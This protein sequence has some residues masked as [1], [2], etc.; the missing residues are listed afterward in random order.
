M[1]KRIIPILLILFIIG[2]ALLSCKGGGKTD[3]SGSAGTPG[4]NTATGPVDYNPNLEAIDGNGR[5]IKF[6]ARE[7]KVVA[8]YWY[9][10]I[11][12]GGD[13]GDIVQQ[14]THVRNSAI[15]DKY[16]I[17]L[18]STTLHFNNFNAEFIKQ[19]GISDPDVG[20]DIVV[21]ML[22]QSFN[23]A[24][25]GYFH[26]IEKLDKIN[27]EKPYW[28]GDIYQAT[29]IGNRNFFIT[30]DINTSVYGSSWTTF[31][32]ENILAQNGIEDP[33]DLVKAG[34]WTIEKMLELS[35]QYGGDANGDGVYDTSDKYAICSGT[36]V[37]QCFFYGSDLRF[38]DKDASDM[39]YIGANEKATLDKIDDVLSRTVT[40]MNTPT[41]AINAN[42]AGLSAQPSKL[43]CSDQVL[44]YFANVNNT[45]IPNDIKDMASDYGMLPLPKYDEAQNYYYNSIHPHHSGSIAVPINISNNLL[46]LISSLIEDMGYYSYINVRPVYFENL[47]TYRSVRNEKS[48]EMIPYIYDRFNIDFGLIMTDSFGF[49]SEIRNKIMKNDTNIS[50]YVSGYASVWDMA[51]RGIVANYGEKT[52]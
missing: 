6:L 32:N 36:W 38:I 12:F 19:I 13:S 2:G 41:L 47:I 8:N 48:L 16:N 42:A 17:K 29:T 10:E 7:S 27:P 15:Q 1:K 9:D 49:D 43:F 44:F 51:L 31:F 24:N 50:S 14:A 18:S 21:P 52:N 3:T 39:P 33:Y 35:K 4:G 34:K 30:G 11:M 5:I 40:I 46:P 45:F 22:V 28:F 23:L 37:W 20:Y 26:S 25:N